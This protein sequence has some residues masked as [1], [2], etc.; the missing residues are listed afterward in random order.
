MR[1][2]QTNASTHHS[3]AVQE[4]HMNSKEGRS[5]HPGI[6]LFWCA[7][8]LVLSDYAFLFSGA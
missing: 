3:S 6:Q 8:Y 2:K 5:E 1:N 7:I 4:E